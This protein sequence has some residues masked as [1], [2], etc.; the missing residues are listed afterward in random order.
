MSFLQPLLLAALPLVALPIIIHLINQRRYQTIRWGAMMFLLAANRMSRG[1]A[2]IRQWL[3]LAFRTL[4]IAGLVFAISRPLASGWL[5]LAAGGRAD[6]SLVIL[7]RSPS[8][9]QTRGA[10]GGSK[11]D[12]A[13]AQLAQTLATLGSA[14][15]LLVDSATSPPLEFESPDALLKSH[16]TQANSAATD[17]PALLQAAY[18]YIRNNQVGQAEVWICSDLRENDWSPASGRWPSLRDAFAAFPQGVRFH[19]LAYPQAASGNTAVRVTSVRQIHN[20]EGAQLLLSLRLTREGGDDS[21]ISVPV[22]FEV[23]GARSELTIE[24]S[25]PQFELKEHVLPL[26]ASHERGWGRVTIPADANLADNDCY[27][28]FD[29]PQ[30]RH[31]LLVTDD[32]PS[33]R[34]LQ[35]AAGIAPEA[36][37]AATVQVVSADGLA[38]VEWNGL[39]LVAWQA[40]LPEGEASRLL[41]AFVDRGG[42]V[43]FFPPAAPGATELFGVRWNEWIEAHEDIPIKT[44]R[45]DHDL[46]AHTLSGAALPVGKLRVRR[47]CSLDG[48]FTP[49][50]ALRGAAPLVARADTSRG[51][52]Y[53]VA[54]TAAP[55]DSSLAVDGV[56]LYV[57]VQRALALG[58]QSLASTRDLAA[59]GFASEAAPGWQRL[60]GDD[61][62]LST[63]YALHRGVYADG[64]RLLAVNRPTAEDMAPVLQDASVEQLFE[65]LDFSRVDGEAGSLASLVHEIWRLFL[66]CMLLALLV[67]AAL[68]LT[69]PTR[70]A[71]GTA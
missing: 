60:A 44:W 33:V 46:L 15:W 62:A 58:A 52:V 53:F 30:P 19:L 7:D 38:G 71:G 56:V 50:A 48:E 4:A 42:S 2:R 36:E 6:T 13:R 59:A 28:T 41:Q 26:P 34:A 64:E 9:Q 35:L 68:C 29:K 45:G 65:G 37:I 5:G 23:A 21:R 25:G 12:S 11:L 24:M 63:E 16:A 61:D 20:A 47:Y 14:R 31:T 69:K 55:A 40:P 70:P 17:L 66:G 18:D 67:E 43:L 39:A 54:T 51:A 1:Y 8:M 57:L 49:L 27:F 10:G 22:Q 3:I 32:E